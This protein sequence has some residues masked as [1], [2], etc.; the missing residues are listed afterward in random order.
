M[1]GIMLKGIV[2][3]GNKLGRK[4]GFPTA[5]IEFLSPLD[6]LPETG[7]YAC[8]VNLGDQWLKGVANFGYRPTVDGHKLVFEVHILDFSENIYGKILQISLAGLIRKEKRFGDLAE[9][10]SQI[11]MDIQQARA[12][13]R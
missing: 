8:L 1:T 11:M 5:N 10:S 9:L 12:L 4:I 3:E 7:V 2:A 6:P 13:L